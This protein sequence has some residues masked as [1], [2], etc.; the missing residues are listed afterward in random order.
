MQLTNH[1]EAP[2]KNTNRALSMSDRL[3]INLSN[4][5]TIGLSTAFSLLRNE[6]HVLI[7]GSKNLSHVRENIKFMSEKIDKFKN[8][9]KEYENIFEKLDE[10]WRQLT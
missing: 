10:N 2:T 4:I 7:I 1:L 9:V 8:N 6:I 3:E 5:D